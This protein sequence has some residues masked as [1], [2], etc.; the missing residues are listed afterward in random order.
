MVINMLKAVK[1]LLLRA[2]QGPDTNSKIYVICARELLEEII[3]GCN[4]EKPAGILEP[5]PFSSKEPTKEPVPKEKPVP[6]DKRQ[7]IVDASRKI[8][9]I[10]NYPLDGK[11]ELDGKIMTHQQAI[12]KT[13]SSGRFIE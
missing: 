8:T 3:A 4:S 2:E 7:I 6:K 12:G 5:V 13:F 10:K 9:G 1:R 11:I